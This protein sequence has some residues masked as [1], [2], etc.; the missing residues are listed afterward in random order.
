[1]PRLTESKLA[2]VFPPYILTMSFK[3]NTFLF[4]SELLLK[5]IVAVGQ[6]GLKRVEPPGVQFIVGLVTSGGDAVL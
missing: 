6:S 2:W 4:Q 1:M 5:G 3:K